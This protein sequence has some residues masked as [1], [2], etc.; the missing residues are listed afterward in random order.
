MKHI[1]LDY[2]ATTPIDK[3]VLDSMIPFLEQ[4]GNFGNSG[5][6]HSF[7]QKAMA[8]I[9]DARIALAK[10]ITANRR[11][12]IFTSGATEANN[13]IIRGVLKSFFKNQKNSSSGSQGCAII[14]RI[15]I[16]AIE[17][18]SVIE[19]V[20]ALEKE[21]A[22]DAVYLPV[23]GAGVV[24]LKAL[25]KNLDDKTILVSV[26]WVNNE[27]GVIQPITEISKI[28]ANF[29]E[30]LRIKNNESGENSKLKIQNSIYP[31]FHT[32]AV[33]A[34]NCFD[35]NV[36]KSGVD[37]MTL[38]S[39]KIYGPKG[40]GASYIKNG[41]ESV[42]EPMATGGDQ[43]YGL[44]SG[45]ENVPAIVGFASA[46]GMTHGVYKT[47]SERLKKLSERFFE[48]IKD[49]FSDVEINGSIDNRSPHIINLYFPGHKNLGMALDMA[50]IAASAGS[51]CAQRYEKPSHVLFAM[52]MDDTRIKGSIRFSFGRFTTPKDVDDA[53]ER[54]II[55]LNK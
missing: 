8:A 5:S 21:G 29:R 32:D 28:I 24:D 18:P 22:I 51:A 33:Q 54:I 37:L 55:V 39:H 1:Y 2:A 3:K 27:T 9:D 14:P 10:T 35:L 7:G 4:E 31:L 47:E 53:I 16:S 25:E 6:L 36:I 19:T 42:I 46:A 15:I 45:T 12:I 13:L 11:E 43:E 34:F 48:K 49:K 30:E 50:G 44:R 38:S 20:R 52:A 40:I 17:H 23:N 26:M 41:V